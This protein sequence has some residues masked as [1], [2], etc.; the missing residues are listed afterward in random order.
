[1]VEYFEVRNK[2]IIKG[3]EAY[4]SKPYKWK[5]AQMKWKFLFGQG[6]KSKSR[7]GTPKINGNVGLSVAV[8]YYI[9]T[10]HS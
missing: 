8:Y 10:H 5:N 4:K 2:K 7:R 6:G 9:T 3:R 1:V